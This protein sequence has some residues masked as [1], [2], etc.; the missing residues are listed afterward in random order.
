MD[1]IDDDSQKSRIHENI[2]DD[3]SQESRIHKRGPNTP[4]ICPREVSTH[5]LSA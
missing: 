1:I 5:C 4:I 3:N 2:I